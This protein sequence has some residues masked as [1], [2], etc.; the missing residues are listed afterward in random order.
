MDC[1]TAQNTKRSLCHPGWRTP[2]VDRNQSTLELH[3]WRRNPSRNGR[4][5]RRCRKK[6]FWRTS[7]R[8]KSQ[9]P[10]FYWPTMNT[11]CEA[12]AQQCD[13]CQRHASTIHRAT[14]LLRTM[15]TPY[16]FMRWRMDI[17]GPMPSSRQKRFVLVLNDFFTKW[18]EAEVFANIT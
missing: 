17:I 3:P 7:T 16:P 1:E 10:R 12:Y 8:L 2:S 15:T 9:K 6:S 18:I 5:A 14:K 11:D 4:N 13:Q